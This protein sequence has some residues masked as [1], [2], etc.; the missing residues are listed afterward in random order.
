MEKE[1]DRRDRAAGPRG[2]PSGAGSGRWARETVG[3]GGSGRW[4]REASGRGGGWA[5]RGGAEAG[6]REGRRRKARVGQGLERGGAS[7]GRTWPSR[8]IR[9]RTK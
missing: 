2:R 7:P 1:G 9:W 4:A 8:L 3:R 6:T 5:A